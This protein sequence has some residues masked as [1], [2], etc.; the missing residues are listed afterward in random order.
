MNFCS[1]VECLVSV[2]QAVIFHSSGEQ[3]TC[4]MPFLFCHL[5]FYNPDSL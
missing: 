4:D 5:M 2:V 1:T 3:G